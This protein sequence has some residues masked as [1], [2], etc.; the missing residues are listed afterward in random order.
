MQ[1]ENIQ[2][3]IYT[4]NFCLIISLSFVF[5]SQVQ[6]I[7]P[8]LGLLSKWEKITK[9]K[10]ISSILSKIDT[11]WSLII[12]SFALLRHGFT[13]KASSSPRRCC[14]QQTSAGLASMYHLACLILFNSC[15]IY[16]G[17]FNKK[18]QTLTQSLLQILTT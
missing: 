18:K 7:C 14:L 17:S 10:S 12:C 2:V 1:N 13:L 6:C 16:S 15:F 5:S 3:L 11:Y 9:H 4:I 8:Y